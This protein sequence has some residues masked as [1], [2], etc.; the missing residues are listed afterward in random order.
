MVADYWQLIF[1]KL[2]NRLIK[3]Q[4]NLKN[5]IVWLQLY[6]YQGAAYYLDWVMNW[7]KITYLIL[8]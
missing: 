3:L 8:P 5:Q 2:F 1:K 4:A 7:S 6:G